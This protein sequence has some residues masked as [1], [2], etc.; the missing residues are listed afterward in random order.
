MSQITEDSRGNGYAFIFSYSFSLIV[1]KG[2]RDR[3]LHI[4]SL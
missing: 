2:S 1:R 4:S 3:L